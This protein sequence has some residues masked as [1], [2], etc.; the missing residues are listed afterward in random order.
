MCFVIQRNLIGNLNARVEICYSSLPLTLKFPLLRIVSEEHFAIG[1]VIMFVQEIQTWNYCGTSWGVRCGIN[2]SAI[3]SR[4]FAHQGIC[5]SIRSSRYR[6]ITIWIF[7][8]CSNLYVWRNGAL[9]DCVAQKI[10]CKHLCQSVWRSLFM[11]CSICLC[12]RDSIWIQD[13]I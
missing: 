10:F 5:T 6:S 12:C 1:V 3:L 4:A 9:S 2:V 13:V 7:I 11:T 8:W